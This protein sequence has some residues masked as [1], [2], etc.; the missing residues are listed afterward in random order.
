MP[1]SSE[2]LLNIKLKRLTLSLRISLLLW[3]IW[4]SQETQSIVESIMDLNCQKQISHSFLV[5]TV[6]LGIIVLKY[7]AIQSIQI[8]L[9][10]E[11]LHPREPLDHSK[12][13]NLELLINNLILRVFQPFLDS[14]LQQRSR[15]ILIRDWVYVLLGR[16]WMRE[17]ADF[18]GVKN[19]FI[20]FTPH[21]FINRHINQW[22]GDSWDC[23]CKMS[24][25]NLPCQTFVLGH[26][27]QSPFLFLDYDLWYR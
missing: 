12:A 23:V 15:I 20:Y 21:I 22:L 3:R 2:F 7:S 14:L 16:Y 27:D 4:N 24:L 9:S 25:N 6:V 1:N 17:R 26:L 5:P 19:I 18:W 8:F 11:L 13:K 10:L